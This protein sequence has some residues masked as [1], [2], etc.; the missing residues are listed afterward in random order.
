MCEGF[1]IFLGYASTVSL[2]I[3]ISVF[4]WL[5]YFKYDF[6]NNFILNIINENLNDKL[7]NSI[8]FRQLCKDNE[9][10][11]ILGT[12]DGTID[13]CDCEGIIFKDKCSKE[14]VE[15]GCKHIFSI[16]PINYTIFNSSSICVTR[17]KL[18]YRE[19]LKSNLIISND[20]ECPADYQ[21]CGIIDTLGRKLCIQIGEACPI[22][23]NIIKNNIFNIFGNEDI[24]NNPDGI[25]LTSIKLFQYLPCI[26]PS[27]KFWNY[28]YDL[29]PQ[30]QRCTTKIKGKLYDERYEKLFNFTIN[31][32]QLYNENSIANKIKLDTE[33]I[34][35][36]KMEEI[37]LF[38]RNF[39]GFD[40]KV[41]KNYN[42]NEL[43]S[44]QK[45]SNRSN[46]AQMIYNFVMVAAGLLFFFLSCVKKLGPE[47]LG[48]KVPV[49]RQYLRCIG[50]SLFFLSNV[51]YLIINIIIFKCNK[52]IKSILNING[53]EIF[54]E[55]VKTLINDI[56]INY[57]YSLA[58]IIITPFIIIL[59]FVSLIL[60][61]NRNEEEGIE[62]ILDKDI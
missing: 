22:N 48:F 14:K 29:E 25:L 4:S 52:A 38:G 45:L 55:M 37:S 46:F 30:D 36:L 8:S 20:K 16:E 56:S 28:Y 9:E 5:K 32:L 47:W 26:F 18:N 49:L 24:T 42:F 40:A 58:I 13:G 61:V 57:R 23:S 10:K 7:I 62:G 51:F 11:L 2:I 1:F 34:Y 17:T 44:K 33:I 41:T 39:L 19:Y 50:A 12:W 54:N 3:L 59:L 6:N 35:K 60:H 53:D 43:I 21:Y 27:E 15:N 31:K